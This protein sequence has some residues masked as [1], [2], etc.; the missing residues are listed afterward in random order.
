MDQRNELYEKYV[1]THAG[2]SADRDLSASARRDITPHLPNDR[3]AAILDVGC[4]QGAL[5]ETL[6]AL[7]YENTCGVDISPE[8]VRIAHSLGV[9][10][11]SL[12]DYRDLLR[13]RSWSA[14][15]ATDLVEHL[16]KD[17][18]LEMFALARAGLVTDG[19]LIVRSPNAMS[20]FGGNYQYSDFT[21]ETFLTPRSFSQ[22][23]KVSGFPLVSTYPCKPLGDSPRGL[24]RRAKFAAYE[25]LMKSVLHAETGRS[26][27]IVTQ[28]FVGVAVA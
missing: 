4:G 18:V 7:G 5:V 15:V 24:L 3:T 2:L 8:Q 11:I 25:R 22:V 23:A 6:I 10:S 26:D 9:S 16:S 12:G 17:Q 13:S 1:T 20:P 28:N 19:V 21:H 27:H 14:I